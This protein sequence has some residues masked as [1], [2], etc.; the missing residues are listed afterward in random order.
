MIIWGLNVAAA[1]KGEAG[2]CGPRLGI[3]IEKCS[4]FVDPVICLLRM[5][6]RNV[7]GG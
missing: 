7:G 3:T 1:S 4:I 2:G 5:I 6:E